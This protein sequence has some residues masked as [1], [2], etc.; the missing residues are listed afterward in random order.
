MTENKTNTAADSWLE[1]VDNQLYKDSWHTTAEHFRN[2]VT[3]DEWQAQITAAR[4]KVGNLQSRTLASSQEVQDLPN[5]PTG[6]YII[7]EYASRFSESGA[8]GERLTL[9]VEAN[10]EPRVVGYYLI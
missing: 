2:S 6:K 7:K 3:V 9:V 1:A 8:I 5:A 4:N 10:G